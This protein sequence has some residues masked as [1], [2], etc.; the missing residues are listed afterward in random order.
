MNVS[1]ETEHS[2]R[3]WRCCEGENPDVPAAKSSATAVNE[4]KS[5]FLENHPVV[6]VL[7]AV[8]LFISVAAMFVVIGHTMAK[9][10]CGE[11]VLPW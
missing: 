8:L 6:S 2:N 7:C 9:A 1:Q 4:K 11:Q 10:L 3:W 5:Q